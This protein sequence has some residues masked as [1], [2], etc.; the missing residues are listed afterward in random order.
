MSTHATSVSGKP[1]VLPQ[2]RITAS[3]VFLVGASCMI[4]A[5]YFLIEGLSQF[6]GDET[7][8]NILIIG[9][10]LF[11][12]TESLCFIAAAS[13]AFHSITWRM[14]LFGLGC[15]LFLFSIAVMTLAQKTAL[16]T[17]INEASAIDEKRGQIREQIA[18]LDRMI[19][20]YRYNA[21][22]QSKS[23]YKDSRALG[24]DSINRA[25]DIE[26]EKSK[27]SE[28]LFLLNQQRKET[29][30]DFF[31]RLEEVTGLP[32]VSTEFYFLVL[33][34]LLLE[35]C[36]II[37]MAFAANLRALISHQRH[38][39]SGGEATTT[40][41]TSSSKVVTQ[42]ES[43]VKNAVAAKAK[44]YDQINQQT[45]QS[46]QRKSAKAGLI[47][48]V[49]SISK[50]LNKHKVA[51]QSETIEQPNIASEIA[52]SVAANQAV[53]GESFDIDNVDLDAEIAQIER[54][55][56]IHNLTQH[57]YSR[58]IERLR[59]SEEMTQDEKEVAAM[60]ASLMELYQRGII[61]T[62][63]REGIIR[64]LAKHHNINIDGDK[65]K[66]IKQY[67]LAENQL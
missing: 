60:G 43:R 28:Q 32:A 11:Q 44:Y 33:R 48:L 13:L 17:G 47:S 57:D 58:Y 59:Q 29:S 5:G 54:T 8:R 23:I 12:I 63:S 67:L 56:N 61:T 30:I 62:L 66:Q 39:D 7:T 65:A 27:L 14:S 45:A 31:I 64:G 3:L 42:D 20:S 19:E 35:L 25:A 53:N 24:Q 16:Q 38:H 40:A 10:I 22:K 36:G 18:S 55:N 52:R 26:M 15:V 4:V 49:S 21:E 51:N 37:L 6:S 9:G 2:N 50:P 41:A 1:H 34:S 46:G